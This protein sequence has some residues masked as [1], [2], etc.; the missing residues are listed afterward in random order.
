MS[1]F[2]CNNCDVKGDLEQ[3]MVRPLIESGMYGK[4]AYDM[5]LCRDC[6]LLFLMWKKRW[7]GRPN[8]RKLE[9]AEDRL[10][11]SLRRGKSCSE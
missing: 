11:F 9:E 7:N 6:Q 5:L 3:L 2:Q 4:M 8:G 10:K 1:I